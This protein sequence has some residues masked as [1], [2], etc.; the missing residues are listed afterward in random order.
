MMEAVFIL[1]TLG[2]AIARAM[3]WMNAAFAVEQAYRQGIA[4]VVAINLMFLEYVAGTARAMLT[5]MAFVMTLTNV[6]D[7]TMNV[8]LR[9]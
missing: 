8:G 7:S 1:G 2:G 5:L 3:F 6:L 4:T 9:W